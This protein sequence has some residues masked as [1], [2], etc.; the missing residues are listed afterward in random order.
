[1][2]VALGAA[3]TVTPGEGNGRQAPAVRLRAP[4]RD[5]REVQGGGVG[6]VSGGEEGVTRRFQR[7]RT[8]RAAVPPLASR[9]LREGGDP[10]GRR[11]RRRGGGGALAEPDGAA[12]H[13]LQRSEPAEGRRLVQVAIV[14]ARALAAPRRRSDGGAANRWG[15]D[16]DVH[17]A[18]DRGA[19]GGLPI[20]LLL[21]LLFLLLLL[22]VI[23]VNTV[24]SLNEEE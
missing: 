1:M 23:L 24:I 8:P 18:L 12:Q 15:G 19:R 11:G 6:G 3:L 16:V 22:L 21:L 10:R 17:L 4:L 20:L 14:A 13:A 5:G 7:R 2:M 9:N